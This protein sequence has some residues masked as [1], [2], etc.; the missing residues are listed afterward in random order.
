MSNIKARLDRLMA[1]LGA[2]DTPKR[3]VISTASDRHR[4]MCHPPDHLSLH[5]P[6]P[7]RPGERPAGWTPM[8]ALT[9]EQRA[10]IG[11]NDVVRA[12]IIP[13]SPRL[14]KVVEQ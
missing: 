4:T 8:V 12:L 1:T 5:V 13:P 6:Y 11:P 14:R 10:L 2:P 3:V 7:G 9:D